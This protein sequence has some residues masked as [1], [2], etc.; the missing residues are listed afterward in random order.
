MVRLRPPRLACVTLLSA[1][2]VGLEITLMRLFSIMLW[3]NFAAMIIS[4]TLL[5]YGASGAA[6]A[7][8]GPRLS[9]RPWTSFGAL[10]SSFGVLTP[11]CY[12]AATALQ[13]NPLEALWAPSQFF[14]LALIYVLLG[15]P[16]FTA[17]GAIGLALY[18]AAGDSGRVYAADLLG[19]GLGPAAA[20][21]LMLV[22]PAESCL[23]YLSGA[24][25]GAGASA[26]IAAGSGRAAAASLTAALALVFLV[27]HSVFEPRMSE[28]KAL[29]RTLLLPKAHILDSSSGP[30]GLI[31][32]AVS[33]EI[34]LR[35]A[36]GLSLKAGTGPPSQIGV[37]VDGNTA[38]VIDSP[39][40]WQG[41]DA[42]D[43]AYLDNLLTAL[44]YRLVQNPYV[45]L[46]GSSGP[47][48]PEMLQAFR[49]GAASVAYAAPNP[50]L[51]EMTTRRL[52]LQGPA[53]LEYLDTRE[54][55]AR[56]GAPRAALHTADKHF[57]LI[58]ADLMHGAS[59]ATAVPGEHLIT[60][61]GVKAM[62]DRLSINGLLAVAA[63]M[64]SPPRASLKLI[65]TAERALRETGLIPG[66]HLAVVR[67]WDMALVMVSRS[68]FKAEET[69]AISGF[70]REKSFDTAY[71]P[72][73][74]PDEAN[75][76]NRL[77]EPYLYNGALRI[78]SADRSAYFEDYRFDIRPATDDRPFFN[79]FM[80]PG[81]LIE[82][83]KKRGSGGL[84][85]VDRDYPILIMTI[86]QAAVAGLIIIIA[87][88]AAGKALG[89]AKAIL[90]RPAIYFLMLGLSFLALEI[91]FL[92]MFSLS[93]GDPLLGAGLAVG[94]F[95][96]FAGTGSGISAIFCS[97]EKTA[98]RTLVLAV[99][100][101]IVF[102][103]FAY[104]LLSQGA[105][106]LLS[107]PLGIRAALLSAAVAPTALCMGM[108][109]PLGLYLVGNIG[110][111]QVAWSW[112]INGWASV[113]SAPLAQL[114]AVHFGFWWVV[115]GAS[116][117][118]LLAAF[119]FRP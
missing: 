13:F 31:N 37:Y 53:A 79:H 10:A 97:D 34:P 88:L 99:V 12:L 68:P 26:F 65:A 106:L 2:A 117:L 95:L 51:A 66:A 109:F 1:S 80:K 8:A 64:R 92:N 23:I 58:L 48:G 67:S 118:Y 119:V 32:T 17:G 16:F 94:V 96:V 98:R 60:V 69:A 85:L 81:S 7:F 75:L 28:Y 78:L 110:R 63:P 35:H 29:P 108:P 47:G 42:R 30:L 93:L 9:K 103:A 41:P 100:G 87:P 44:A 43:F 74:K 24:A 57:D 83:L 61:Q 91:A 62:L 105:G 20:I 101:V 59:A 25:F 14:R 6:L 104:T 90:A 40:P 113:L 115:A 39:R 18:S 50:E 77:P 52:A 21:S 86:F 5:G 11:L 33:P 70:C 76:R 45:F 116:F 73:M 89:D 107:L 84:A 112:G 114:M 111:R 46:A 15:A 4:L 19:A 72:G 36:A 56:T 27:P 102:S 3:Q 38:G 71:F 55:S 22:F 54:I 49:L 82:L